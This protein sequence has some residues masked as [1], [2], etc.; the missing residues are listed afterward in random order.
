MVPFRGDG[1]REG[2]EGV[3]CR[4]RVAVDDVVMSIVSWWVIVL[5]VVGRN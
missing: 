5:V 1:G 3:H 4:Y 2:G